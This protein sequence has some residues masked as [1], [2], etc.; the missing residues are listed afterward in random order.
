MLGINPYIGFKG[1][2]REAVEFY[3]GALDAQVLFMQTYGGSPMAEMGPAEHIMH[4]TIQV[5]GSTVMMCDEPG[6]A[7]DA[8]SSGMISLAI[9]LNDPELAARLFNNL[10]VGGTVEMPLAKT[11]WAEAFGVVTDK[12]GVKWMINCDAPKAA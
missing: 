9:G 3:K 2:C 10:A 7:S 12:F 4:S 8:P 1:T 5:G 11:F 6:P